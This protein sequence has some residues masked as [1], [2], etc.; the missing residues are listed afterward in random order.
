MELL[1]DAGYRGDVLILI[2]TPTDETERP[3]QVEGINS[4]SLPLDKFQPRGNEAYFLSDTKPAAK[5]TFYELVCQQ[6][7]LTY[8]QFPILSHV[9]CQIASSVQIGSGTHIEQSTILAPYASLGE[10]INIK[11]GGNIGHHTRIDDFASINPGVTVAG[12]CHIER[13]VLIGVGCTIFDNINIGRGSIIGG[14]SVV[15]KDIPP[16]VIAFGNPCKVI[17]DI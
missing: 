10:Y 1:R 8:N 9:S 6:H 11:R 15:T 12:K 5:K 17:R 14:G 13:D 7:G 3:Y 4:I 2:A 16:G